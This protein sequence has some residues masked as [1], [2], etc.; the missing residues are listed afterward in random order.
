MKAAIASSAHCDVT[1][2]SSLFRCC[3]EWRAEPRR[4]LVWKPAP[5]LERPS[6]IGSPKWNP[7]PL[8]VDNS[9]A[10][11]E[12]NGRW[13]IIER[14]ARDVLLVQVQHGLGG[15][16]S[17]TISNVDHMWCQTKTQPKIKFRNLPFCSPKL[18]LDAHDADLEHWILAEICLH[19]QEIAQ[20]II[21]CFRRIR[22]L[23]CGQQPDAITCRN[24]H[25]Q[26][27]VRRLISCVCKM[28]WHAEKKR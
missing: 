24:L 2:T 13:Q 25:E 16:Q 10:V 4:G 12:I 18:R 27:I 14:V 1:V 28:C 5:R 23:R 21:D 9:T 26:V 20:D 7:M 6:E 17:L 3:D 22:S 8:V 11:C 19:L 15:R